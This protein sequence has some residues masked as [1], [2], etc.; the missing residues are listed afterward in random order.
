[1]L[2]SLTPAQ[3]VADA[4]AADSRVRGTAAPT[5]LRFWAP[6]YGGQTAVSE[7]LAQPLWAVVV[8]GIH[9][10][11]PS[12]APKPP[13]I[14]SMIFFVSDPSGAVALELGCPKS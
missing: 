2:P 10:V 7:A 5:F 4:R 3:V 6:P 8:T 11:Y 1:V 12:P 14:G 9:F 13:S